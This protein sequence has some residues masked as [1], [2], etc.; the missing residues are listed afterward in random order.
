MRLHL[1]CGQVHLEEYINIDFP[2]SEH[3]VQETSVADEFHDLTKLH[4]KPKTIDEVRLHHTFEHFPRHIAVALLASWHTWLK[5]GGLIHIEV[6][7]FEESTKVVLDQ[8]SSD[9]DRKV[10]LRHIF[11]S[12]EASW[13]T[14]YEG[15]TEDHFRQLFKLFG[16]KVLKIEKTAYLATRNITV[17]AKKTSLIELTPK[18][19]RNL[20]A[21]YLE[22][23]TVND[24]AFEKSLLNIWLNEFEE[25][26]RISCV[27]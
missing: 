24:S 12:N 17:L 27:R 22:G 25:Q 20:A 7:D 21:K 4:Y 23:F 10:A 26:F 2:L 8:A 14:H 3:T 16:F 13:A 1:G 19:A 15:W 11:G 9:H 5:R 18:K 6:P